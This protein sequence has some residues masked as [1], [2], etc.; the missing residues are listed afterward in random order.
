M[1]DFDKAINYGTD[2]I[3]NYN[4]DDVDDLDYINLKERIVKE[5]VHINNNYE[6]N[7][8]LYNPLFSPN[9]FITQHI[10]YGEQNKINK[11]DFDPYI[12]YLNNNGLNGKNIKVRYN[13]E[14]INIDSMNRDKLPNN[15]TSNMYKLNNNPLSIINNKL[16]INLSS[17]I[18]NNLNIGDK[19]SLINV[20][21]IKNSYIAFGDLN[22]NNQIYDNNNNIIQQPLLIQF[23]KGKDYA[24]ISINPNFYFKDNINLNDSVNFSVLYK[25]FDT[26]KAKV[27]IS[28]LKGVIKET[29][30]INNN[31][32]LNYFQSKIQNVIEN[33]QN[34]QTIK[35]LNDSSYPY[36][37]NIPI[38]FINQTHQIYF[39]PP[40]EPT[41]IPSLSKFYIQLPWISDG[42]NIYSSDDAENYNITISFNHYNLIPINEL[43]ADYPINSEHINGY[44][45]VNSIDNINNNIT[46]LINPP[47]DAIYIN[48]N[49]YTYLNFGGNNIYL[50]PVT[51]IAYGYPNQNNYIINLNKMYNNVIQIK[52]IDSLFINPSITFINDG[53]GKN[54]RLYFQN[55]EDIEQIQ[56]IEVDEGTYDINSLISSIEYKFS[57]LSRNINSLNFGYDL[58]Y[59]ITIDIDIPTNITTIKSYKTKT[60]LSPISNVTPVINQND[61]S[62]GIGTYT[63][64]I[65][66]PNHGISYGNP[67]VKFSGFIDHLGIPADSLNGERNIVIIDE[68][69]YSFTINN[70][71]LTTNKIITNGGNTVKVLLPSPLKLYFN[72]PDTMGSIL[73]YRNTGYDTSI[74]NYNYIQK[75]T[76]IYIG[77]INKDVNGN[78]ILLKNKAIKLKKYE[79]FLMNCNLTHINNLSNAQKKEIF[80]AKFKINDDNMI[81]DSYSHT[82]IYFYDPILQLNQLGFS[83][84]NPDNTP[85][86][87][88]DKD[89]SFTLEITTIDNLPELTSINP[90][91]SLKS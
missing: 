85:V 91:I 18:I 19:F 78:I 58:N 59:N 68:N 35:Y 5:K 70:V 33:T 41:I 87:F 29:L 71:N 21:Q 30:F 76:D 49:N 28:G 57:Q 17:E 36:I 37:G 24:Q 12:N 34:I 60:L 14:Y 45:I 73:G 8:R 48:N 75:N 27:A 80:F 23:F 15:I 39:I 6:E 51:Q 82:P 72:Y 53:N 3:M 26:T 65:V 77:E 20:E 42:T 44:H 62:I 13:V 16:Q 81:I 38:S 61:L 54:N 67:L 52:L 74:T 83:F 11:I 47:I 31:T 55:I 46:I 69:R 2:V 50:S 56:Y 40:S 86:D 43:I 89:H 10:D 66:H 25:Y 4:R 64:T 88:K 63:I 90:N 32:I 22:Y 79:Y 1:A 7:T 84:Y 9:S